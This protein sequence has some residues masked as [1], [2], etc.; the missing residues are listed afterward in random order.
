MLE[1]A[2]LAHLLDR[3]TQISDLSALSLSF[4]VSFVDE[5]AGKQNGFRFF[6]DSF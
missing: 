5:T 4:L 6:A 1:D 2:W 3:R